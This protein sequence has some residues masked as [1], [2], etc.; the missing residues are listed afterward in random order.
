MKT[1]DTAQTIP[2]SAIASL[3]NVTGD[4]TAV[5]AWLDDAMPHVYTSRFNG[6]SWTT[7]GTAI[8]SSAQ[9]QRF[10]RVAMG[11]LLAVYYQ[12]TK[13]SPMAAGNWEIHFSQDAT[14]TA[15][16]VNDLVATW[17]RNQVEAS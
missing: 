2:L 11:S 8:D 10:P 5:L 3:R 9:D 17:D 1:F 7:P 6:T 15:D 14:V 4:Y 16:R 12:D 13:A